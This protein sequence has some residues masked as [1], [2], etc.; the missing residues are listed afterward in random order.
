MR[1]RPRGWLFPLG[2]VLALVVTIGVPLLVLPDH[3]SQAGGQ[4]P[5]APGAG[6][7]V[8]AAGDAS[9]Q[10]VPGP[11][12]PIGNPLSGNQ[13]V[14]ATFDLGH[15]ASFD[16][17]SR[18]ESWSGDG[19]VTLA[20]ALGTFSGHFAI[21]V[22]T[23]GRDCAGTVVGIN[24]LGQSSSSGLKAMKSGA[25]P[26]LLLAPAGTPFTVSEACG[27]A[28]GSTRA[29]IIFT[30]TAPDSVIA[31]SAEHQPLPQA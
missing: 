27:T 10:G 1:G 24:G 26:M 6:A 21:G 11:Q 8:G 31:G 12:N 7:P 22:N 4:T 3:A 17:E 5:G 20:S 15:P 29:V 28:G 19:P 18:V 14:A 13:T 30:T 23:Q 16:W 25:P 9:L 2:L